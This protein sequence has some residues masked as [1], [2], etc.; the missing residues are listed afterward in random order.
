M[1]PRIRV[2][3][4]TSAERSDVYGVITLA[5]AADPITRWAFPDPA[6]YLS[7]MPA[8]VDAFCGRGFETDSV[9]VVDGLAGAAA[10]LA[11]GVEPDAPRLA[12]IVESNAPAERRADVFRLLEEQGRYH[13]HEPHWY[14]PMIGV[15][16]IQHGHGYGAALMQHALERCDREQMPAYLESTN[17]RNISLY[18]RFGFEVLGRIEVGG[19]PPMTPMLRGRR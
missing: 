11:P 19:S 10:W 5:F 9:Y 12:A 4:A 18:K 1:Q 2:R 17:P 7:E 3:A 8:F 13:P 16:P 6:R 14:L 15:D